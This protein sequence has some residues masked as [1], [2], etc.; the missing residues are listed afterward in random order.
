MMETLKESIARKPYY[1]FL[2]SAILLFVL[3]F[4]FWGQTIDVHLHDTY[5]VI[6]TPYFIWGLA[7]LFLFGWTIYQLMGRVLWTKHLTWFHVVVSLFLLVLLLTVNWWHDKL[8]PPIK[9]GY[10]S[11]E[12]LREDQLRERRVFLPLA[13][14]FLTSQLAFILNL[15]GGLIKKVVQKG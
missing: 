8:V 2:L 10:S 7:L 5:L 13:L 3:S 15:L 9:R 4:A 11:W 12:T 6:A 1:L 14:L